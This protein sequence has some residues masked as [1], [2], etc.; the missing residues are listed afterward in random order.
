[1]RR[2]RPSTR[3]YYGEGRDSYDVRGRVAHESI[4]NMNDG[5]Y[6]CPNSQQGYSPF[7]TWTR[8]LAWIMCGYAEQL[9]FLDICRD[10]GTQWSSAVA[11]RSRR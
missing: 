10:A 9:E 2:R 8:G 6:R 5:D 11:G 1:M 3:S 4:F 7:T